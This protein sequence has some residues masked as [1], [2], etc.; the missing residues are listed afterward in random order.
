MEYMGLFFIF[1]ITFFH[2]QNHFPRSFLLNI[3]NVK[4]NL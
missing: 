3:T 2:T 1:Q 4:Q